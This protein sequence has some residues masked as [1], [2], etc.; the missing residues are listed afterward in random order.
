MKKNG[1]DN[2]R[3]S[4]EEKDGCAFVKIDGEFSI[5]EASTLRGEFLECFNKYNGLIL[6]L[7]DVTECDTAGIQLLCSARLTA[8][9][10]GKI[11]S[12]EKMAEPVVNALISGGLAPEKIK[13]QKK[14]V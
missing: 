6:D 11:F 10:E 7:S 13:Y 14:E 9:K 5:Y 1:E 2:M 12:V 3:L 4:K 8:E